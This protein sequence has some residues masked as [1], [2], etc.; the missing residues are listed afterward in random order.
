MKN[1]L[2]IDK[3]RCKSCG[4]CVLQCKKGLLSLSHE[5]NK[6][7]YH[8][9]MIAEPDKCIGCTMCSIMCPDSVIEVYREED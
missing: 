8:P 9:V 7:G 5:I 1:I 3:D 6:Q 4:L 2:V